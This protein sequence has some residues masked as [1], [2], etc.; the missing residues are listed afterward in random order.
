MSSLTEA[1]HISTQIQKQLGMMEDR[2][3]EKSEQPALNARNEKEAETTR[4]KVSTIAR[5]MEITCK[6]GRM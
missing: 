4:Q 1:S 5:V 6:K 3:K 2:E